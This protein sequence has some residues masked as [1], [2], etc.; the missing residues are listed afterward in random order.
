MKKLL[1][2]IILLSLILAGCNFPQEPTV[3]PTSIST[4]VSGALTATALNAPTKAKDT[5]VPLVT[6]T[7]VPVF[8]ATKAP[9]TATKV[10]VTATPALTLTTTPS[11]TA[12]FTQTVTVDTKDPKITLGKSTWEDKFHD[13]GNWGL[14]TQA[15]D[16]GST[17]VEIKNDAL[18]F[19]SKEGKGWHG[20][21]ATYPKPQKY[22]LEATVHNINCGNGDYYGLLF[23]SQDNYTGYWFGISC[24][25]KFNLRTGGINGW[26]E[27]VP[28]E[29][30]S[31]ILAGA[32]KT[33]RL[34]VM[35]KGDQLTLYING[36]PVKQLTDNTYP[37]PGV[38][39]MF[40]VGWNQNFAFETEEMAYWELP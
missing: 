19:L 39:G 29:A 7:L 9:I 5:P 28:V 23:Q 18:Y 14:K 10:P 8:T 35:V 3:N 34:G 6:T 12:T 26:K 2:I 4:L 37:N 22:Y 13:G 17:R 30:N 33:N 21:R 24:Q 31:A 40:I 36:K 20:W 15:Y 11:R 38:F 27:P 1:V 25:G 16:D 32:N